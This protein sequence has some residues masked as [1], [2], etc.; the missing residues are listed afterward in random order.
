MLLEPPSRKLLYFYLANDIL[1]Q[2]RR[3]GDEFVKAFREILPSVIPYLT[4]F[5]CFGCVNCDSL[6]ADV[7]KK[8]ARIF[9]IWQER[10]IYSEKFVR[11]ILDGLN[12]KP[13]VREQT[14]SNNNIPDILKPVIKIY[15]ELEKFD[16]DF[17]NIPP[18]NVQ[19]F[20]MNPSDY[21]SAQIEDMKLQLS[22]QEELVEDYIQVRESLVKTLRLL[23]D[24]QQDKIEELYEIQN[25]IK[26]DQ[27][28]LL[29]Q[30]DTD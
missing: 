9:N 12:S 7:K 27:D 10:N 14:V 18:V 5:F 22:A 2:G 1:Q 23:L 15:Q 16:R 13:V 24:N 29:G 3:R 28:T 30:M 26:N 19:D 6:N 8:I 25:N 21:D 4:P 17:N 20:S 11:S